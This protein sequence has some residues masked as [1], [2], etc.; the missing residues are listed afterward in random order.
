M[1]CLLDQKYYLNYLLLHFV[2]VVFFY[3]VISVAIGEGRDNEMT[4]FMAHVFITDTR[5]HLHDCDYWNTRV[6]IKS[7][8][9]SQ[10]CPSTGRTTCFKAL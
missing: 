2:V 6:V 5:D 10:T 9:P 3:Y 7:Q 1:Y 8:R 4:I